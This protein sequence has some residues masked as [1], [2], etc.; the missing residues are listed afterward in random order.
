MEKE[1]KTNLLYGKLFLTSVGLLILND[2]YLKYHFHNY[3]TGKLSDFVGLFAFAYFVSLFFK[4]NIK[5]IYVLTGIAFLFWKSSF[6][7]FAIAFMNNIGVGINRIV[8]YSDLI[9]LSILPISYCYRVNHK[10]RVKRINLLPK[11]LII[12]ICIFSFVATT[13][14]REYTRLDLKANYQVQIDKPKDSVKIKLDDIYSVNAD[15]TFRTILRIPEKR[16][17]IIVSLVITSLEN[18]QTNIKLDSIIG[19]V[20]TGSSFLGGVRRKNVTYVKNL[21][22][23]DFEQLFMEQKINPIN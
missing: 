7:Q 21:K 3:L 4:N 12:G 9:A 16:S 13:L 6:S 2:F 20:T 22:L 19:C 5:L 15:S 18:G 8:D 11:Q 10:I 1:Q 23:T 17:R 14:P